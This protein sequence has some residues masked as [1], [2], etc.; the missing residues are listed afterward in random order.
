M[1]LKGITKMAQTIEKIIDTIGDAKALKEGNGVQHIGGR[2][3]K[4]KAGGK[5]F[6]M[7]K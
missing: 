2:I 5:V 4:K 6:K 7:L 3:I 1:K